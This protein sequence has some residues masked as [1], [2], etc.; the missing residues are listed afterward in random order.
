MLQPPVLLTCANAEIL[1]LR[2]S[3]RC[4]M[5]GVVAMRSG[6]HRTKLRSFSGGGA[7]QPMSRAQL[8]AMGVDLVVVR[9]RAA[10]RRC[11]RGGY[12]QQS[13]IQGR[14]CHIETFG[15]AA[16]S[17]GVRGRSNCAAM[18]GELGF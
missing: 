5:H 4:A 2:W 3:N 7:G 14:K 9:L 1:I 10:Q 12:E 11:L 16:W 18:N 13:Q 15:E 17:R 8:S 6:C